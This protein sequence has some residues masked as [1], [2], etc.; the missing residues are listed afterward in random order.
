MILTTKHSEDLVLSVSATYDR[1]RAGSQD[2]VSAGKDFNFAGQALRTEGLPQQLNASTELPDMQR[3]SLHGTNE[4]FNHASQFPLRAAA[5]SARQSSSTIPRPSRSSRHQHAQH[6]PY[7]KTSH[8]C[9][10]S[11]G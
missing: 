8:L 6:N 9:W 11:P 7:G 4:G 3:L 2:S 10:L 5:V 1:R